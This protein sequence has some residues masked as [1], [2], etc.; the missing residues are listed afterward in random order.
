MKKL[1]RFLFE[2]TT[3]CYY[4]KKSQKWSRDFYIMALFNRIVKW[5]GAK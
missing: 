2:K 5:G 1:L 3:Y 4:D